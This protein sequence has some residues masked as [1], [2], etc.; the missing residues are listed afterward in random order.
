MSLATLVD[1]QNR[2]GREITDV[3]EQRRVQAYLDDI[4]ALVQVYCTRGIP[5]PIPGDIVAVVCEEVIAAMNSAP[6]LLSDQT[7]D[8]REAFASNAGPGGLSRQAKVSLSRLRFKMTSVLVVG[9]WYD[10][11]PPN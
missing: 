2:L 9:D 6:G 10:Y 3:W 8:V 11:K 5:T 1:V 4:S 7:G